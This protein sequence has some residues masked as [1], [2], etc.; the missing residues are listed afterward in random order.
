MSIK[1]WRYEQIHRDVVEFE[2]EYEDYTP[3]MAEE[4]IC[5]DK[6]YTNEERRYFLDCLSGA[7]QPKGLLDIANRIV[8]RHS[9]S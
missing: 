3:E 2:L 6:M 8:A 9:Q 7:V 4:W 1:D 5:L